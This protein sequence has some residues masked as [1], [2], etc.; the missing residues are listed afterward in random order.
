MSEK[1]TDNCV[2][3]FR[4]TNPDKIQEILDNNPENSLII[5]WL[6]NKIYENSKLNGDKSF[7]SSLE[8]M[9]QNGR[10]GFIGVE[11]S[12]EQPSKKIYQLLV[13]EKNNGKIELCD[14][15]KLANTDGGLLKDLYSRQESIGI[16]FSIVN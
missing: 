15:I 4:R 12:I 1:Y 5:L 10:I 2:V 14:Q 6:N 16:E 11:S 13:Y 9:A 8:A 3:K 7:Q